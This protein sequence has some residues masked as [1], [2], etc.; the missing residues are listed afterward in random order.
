MKLYLTHAGVA[1]AVLAV[2]VGIVSAQQAPF[3]YGQ[4]AYNPA[5]RQA[6]QPGPPP[7]QVRPQ[8]APQRVAQAPGYGYQPY[9]GQQQV[10]QQQTTPVGYGYPQQP[11]FQQP[12]YQQQRFAMSQSPT[13][14]LPAPTETLTT[15]AQQSSPALSAPAMS[16]PAVTAAPHMQAQPAPAVQPNY[17]QPTYTQPAP[18]VASSYPAAGATSADCGCNQQAAPAATPVDWQSYTAPAAGGCNTGY[19]DAGY[20]ST[21]CA[22]YGVSQYCDQ[23]PQR[24]W[25]FG[26]YGLYMGRDRPSKVKSAV[27]VDGAPAGTYYPQ[28]TDTFLT[29]SQIDPS[30]TGGAEIRFGSTFG[31]ATDACG[32][33]NY[34]PFAW[35][36]GYWALGEDSDQAVMTDTLGGTTRIYGLT[37]YTGLEGDRDGIGGGTWAYRPV[38]DYFDAYMP[39]DSTSTN[40]VRVLG[41]RVRQSFQ[42]QN[43]ELNFWRFGTP[44][45]TTYGSPSFNGLANVGAFGGGQACGTGSCGYG[46]GS[47]G[48]GACGTGSCGYDACGCGPAL[49][50]K[51]FFISG[52]AGVR[53]FKMDET[54][55]QDIMYTTVDGTGTPNAGEPGAYTSFPEDG[56]NNIFDEVQTDNDLIG[57]QLGCSMNCL[58]GCKWTLFADTNFGIYGNQIDSYRRVFASGDGDIRFIET[59]N[60]AAVRNSKTD[61]AFLGEVRTGVGYQLNCN[62]RL[63]AA[64]RAIAVTGVALAGNQIRTPINEENFGHID[65]NGS[66]IIHGLQTGIECKY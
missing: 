1:I 19:A 6:Y 46:A 58:V 37:D 23:G 21:G 51:R 33:T 36:V 29:S 8:P 60:D 59:G 3:G 12:N 35:E 34:Q 26:A 56:F 18:A 39:I 61:V 17:S 30:F 22:D 47:C 13:P 52:L 49:P 42:V 5:Q 15:P 41:V 44:S 45:P 57:F 31:C 24:Q 64:Y 48:T 20:S 55:G 43:L 62:W 63:T 50:A 4:Q 11:N 2:Q 40:D 38:N 53:Y 16:T 66:I 7:Q 10:A 14:E 54:F 65:S 9:A 28:P 27:L 32:C 25:F